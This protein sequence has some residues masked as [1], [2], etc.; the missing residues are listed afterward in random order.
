[1]LKAHASAQVQ[2]PSSAWP[3]QPSQLQ[4]LPI[5]RAFTFLRLSPEMTSPA[6]QGTWLRFMAKMQN[7]AKRPAPMPEPHLGLRPMAPP[8]IFPGG[9]WVPPPPPPQRPSSSQDG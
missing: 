8:R 5:M 2:A 7:N 9:N 4:A 6:Y 3:G 1:M